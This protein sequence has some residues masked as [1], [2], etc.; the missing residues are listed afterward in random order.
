MPTGNILY[1]APAFLA[2][3]RHKTIRGVQVFDLLFVRDLVK[4]GHNVTL[5]GEANWRPRFEEHLAGARPTILYTPPL[6]KPLPCMLWASLALRGRFDATHLGNPAMGLLPGLSILARRGM[7]G[8]LTIQANKAPSERFAR[9]VSKW[10]PVYPALSK[11]VCTGS[12][13]WMRDKMHVYYGIVNPEE[14]Y[15]PPTP[16][17]PEPVN[18]ILVGKLDN[19][20]KGAPEALDAWSRLDPAVRKRCR[21]HLVSYP[22]PPA[23][24][25]EGVIAH[26]WRPASD[27][28]PLLRQMHVMLVPSTNN[29]ETFSQAMVQG[30]LTA[31]PIIVNDLPVLTEKLDAGGGLI[32]RSNEQLAQHITTLANDPALRQSMGQA[33]RAVAL[34]RYIWDSK[35]FVNRFLLRA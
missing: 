33:G 30:M 6:R 34:Q 32:S 27:I 11:G 26:P 1:L 2:D 24:L 19:L 31:L 15:P 20:W 14:F 17:P 10:S 12:P 35:V 25:P 23:N 28:P 29:Q 9:W 13:A 18:F 16:L 3:R 5:V 7:L 4:L 8:K 22:N 21:L